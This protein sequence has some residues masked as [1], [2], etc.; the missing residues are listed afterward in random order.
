[1][2]EILAPYGIRGWIKVRTH[3]EEPATMLGY[4]AWALKPPHVAQ[5]QERTLVAGRMHAG[6]LVAQ[7][8]GV[9]SREAALRLKGW[10][11]GVPRSAMPKAPPGEIYWADLVGLTVVNR[12]GTALGTVTEVTAH[13]A[14]PLLR[15]ASPAGSERMIPYVPAIVLQVDV[16]AGR[17]EVDWDE[18]Y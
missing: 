5:W 7:L 9:D 14:H 17:I 8:S 4:P 12:A 6:A 13:G 1:M 10:Q 18:S 15:V 3:T 16:D 11:I 2:G